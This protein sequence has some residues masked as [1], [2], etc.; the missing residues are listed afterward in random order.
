MSNQFESTPDPSQEKVPI[1]EVGDTLTPNIPEGQTADEWQ[2]FTL[3]A[4]E[5]SYEIIRIGNSPSQ[6]Q[7]GR[8]PLISIAEIGGEIIDTTFSPEFMSLFFKKK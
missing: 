2:M 8:R 5:K 6:W 4:A 1:Y 7:D 3:L